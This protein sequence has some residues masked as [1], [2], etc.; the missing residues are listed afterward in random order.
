VGT[1]VGT[2]NP[3]N[4]KAPKYGALKYISGGERGI[5]TLDTLLTYTHFPGVLLKP[6]GHLS[7]ILVSGRAGSKAH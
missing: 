3:R 2:A 4:N 7:A 1:N 5:R 6:L